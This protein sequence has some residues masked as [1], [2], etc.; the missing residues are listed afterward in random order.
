MN[1]MQFD[2]PLIAT[3]GMLRTMK[4]KELQLFLH[5]TKTRSF[6]RT[7]E[8]CHVS[9]SSLSRVIKRMEDE[10]GVSLFDRDNRHVALTT[11]G[12]AFREFADGTVNNWLIL[13]DRLA[14]QKQCLSGEIS[15]FCSV[16]AS[17][18]FLYELLS[19]FR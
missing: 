1:N 15:L 12:H 11:A 8:A 6:A 14:Q 13:K 9:P 5:L 2:V 4:H 10:L 17:Y 16:T 18:S 19:K 7:S 3:R